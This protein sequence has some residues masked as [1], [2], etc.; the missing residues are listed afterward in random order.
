MLNIVNVS[1][2]TSSV[3]T[4]FQTAVVKPLLKKLHLVPRSLNNYRP[5]SKVLVIELCHVSAGFGPRI[6]IY[7]FEPCLSAFKAFSLH[8]DSALW[9][10][11]YGIN[12]CYKRTTID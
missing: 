9:M 7:R 2:T 4:S 11:K 8:C 12:D 1:L 6:Y 5:A 10:K 3:P